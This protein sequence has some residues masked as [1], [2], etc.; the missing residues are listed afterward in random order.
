MG[1]QSN[2]FNGDI[3]A[4]VYLRRFFDMELMLPRQGSR[5]FCEYLIDGYKLKE[6][7]SNLNRNIAR[8]FHGIEIANFTMYFAVF[9][10]GFALSLRDLDYCIRLMAVVSKNV[11]NAPDLYPVLIVPLI[12]LRVKNSEL[13]KNFVAGEVLA[14]EVIDY[15]Y[16]SLAHDTENDRIIKQTLSPYIECAL[17]ATD[18]GDPEDVALEE[19]KLL[20]DGERVTHLEYLSEGTKK[21]LND[22]RLTVL[23]VVNEEPHYPGIPYPKASKTTLSHI[24][25]LI[26]SAQDVVQK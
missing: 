15:F 6:T 1:G 3:D 14:K 19:L 5:E 18:S 4:N 26:D 25:G 21:R 13:Y 20:S 17:Y 8:H 22:G 23:R 12:L 16:E 7:F 9:C 11:V 24:S 10:S 2:Q